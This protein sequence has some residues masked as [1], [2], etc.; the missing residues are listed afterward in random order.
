MNWVPLLINICARF[1][2]DLLVMIKRKSIMFLVVGFFSSRCVQMYRNSMSIKVKIAV[3]T[4]LLWIGPIIS[5]LRS[6]PIWVGVL[7]LWYSPRCWVYDCLYC[8]H[9]MQWVHTF[10]IS[11][12]VFPVVHLIFSFLHISIIWDTPGWMHELLHCISFRICIKFVSSSIDIVS[13]ER[14]FK[15]STIFSKKLVFF[16]IDPSCMLV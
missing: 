5:M 14:L 3:G 11:L 4:I 12:Y 10:F 1:V 9:W 13:C 16:C 15:D 2:S 7:I 6:F 8:W